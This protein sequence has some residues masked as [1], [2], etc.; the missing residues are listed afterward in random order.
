[1]CF[2]MTFVFLYIGKSFGKLFGDDGY[3]VQ[4]LFDDLFA[5][6]K[7]ELVASIRRNR[8]NKF[9]IFYRQAHQAS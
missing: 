7:S 6:G 5:Q 3:T 4:K 1:M 2:V 9:R 8:K